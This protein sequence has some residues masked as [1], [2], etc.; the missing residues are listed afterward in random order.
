MSKVSEL[1][2]NKD[3]RLTELEEAVELYYKI[4]DLWDIL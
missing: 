4:P 2:M 1:T 3:G